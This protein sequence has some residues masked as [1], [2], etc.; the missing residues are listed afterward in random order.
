MQV[1][2]KN[3]PFLLVFLTQRKQLPRQHAGLLWCLYS[4]WGRTESSPGPE[5]AEKSR[6]SV[7]CYLG[8]LPYIVVILLVYATVI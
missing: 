2:G 6:A 3:M 7:V 1:P 8:L 5:S 4:Q